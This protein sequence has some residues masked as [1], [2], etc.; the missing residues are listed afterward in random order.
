MLHF[1]TP[2]SCNASYAEGR[3]GPD[4]RRVIF[5]RTG[6]DQ[7]DMSLFPDDEDFVFDPAHF[8]P[9]HPALTW[10]SLAVLYTWRRRI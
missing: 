3:T 8:E 9:E 1:I 5:R 7:F 10:E 2:P 6:V 4:D